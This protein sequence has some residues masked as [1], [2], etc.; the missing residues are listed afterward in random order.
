MADPPDRT[1]A[2]NAREGGSAN[3]VFLSKP[4]EIWSIP[5]GTARHHREAFLLLPDEAASFKVA[6]ISVYAAD[7]SDVRV[8]YVSVDLGSNSQSRESISVSVYR[9]PGSL[10][11]EWASVLD[12]V[13]RKHPGSRPTDPFP[14]PDK[15][16]P[17]TKQAAMVDSARSGDSVGGTFVQVSLFHTNGWAVRYEISCP[18]ADVAIARTKTRAFLEYLRERD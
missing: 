7:G 15:H 4:W 5:G 3:D 14:L 1:Q 13:K 10:D 12:H 9:A 11:G 16:P 6:D 17:E 2:T 8:D 18:L